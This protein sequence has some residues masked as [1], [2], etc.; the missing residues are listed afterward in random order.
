MTALSIAAGR[1]A[2]LV[3][4]ADPG[5]RQSRRRTS[6]TAEKE[7]KRPSIRVTTVPQPRTGAYILAEHRLPLQGIVPCLSAASF[8]P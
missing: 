7:R 3:K 4:P 8:S 2:N 6:R 5:L 1:L